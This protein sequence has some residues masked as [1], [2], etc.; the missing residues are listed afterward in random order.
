MLFDFRINRILFFIGMLI[1]FALTYYLVIVHEVSSTIILIVA[2]VFVFAM[3]FTMKRVANNMYR[4]MHQLL[5]IY[6][7]AEGYFEQV[8]ML[9]KR[10]SRGRK[11]LQVAKTQNLV[12]A[13]L[14][15]GDFEEASTL[16]QALLE[17]YQTAI[18]EQS[19]MRFSQKLIDTMLVLFN[20]DPVAF[21]QAYRILEEEIE[22]LP[23]DTQ[24]YVKTNDYSIF[25]MIKQLKQHFEAETILVE[26]LEEMYKDANEF[27]K[28]AVIYTLLRNDKITYTIPESLKRKDGNTLFYKDNERKF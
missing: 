4:Y 3:N 27:L 26:T 17:K 9:Y 5:Y 1:L 21:E 20:Y 15:A 25:Y 8:H 2:L 28:T 12:M 6:A 11:L 13:Y 7:D 19:Q 10:S 23:P 18:Y 14:F 24:E 16:N 22:T